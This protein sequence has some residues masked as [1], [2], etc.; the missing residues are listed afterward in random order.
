VRT[1]IAAGFVAASLAVATSAYATPAIGIEIFIDGTLVN[2]M[3]VT[4]GGGS[5]TLSF[6]NALF[7]SISVTA[8]GAPTTPDPNFGTISI[9][10]SSAFTSGTHTL[11]LVT[12]QT[13][14]TGSGFGGLANSFTYNGL[15]NPGNVTSAIGMNYVDAGDAA[16]ALTT[17]LASSGN[18]G[19]LATLSTGPI[20]FM[21]TPPPTF[22]E[23]EIYDFTFKGQALAQSSAQITGVPEP[24]SIA[25]LGTGLI[26]LGTIRRR[27][28]QVTT[29]R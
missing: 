16:Y 20:T 4:S 23:T 14:L 10:A 17:L 9:S 3:P 25:L 1:L 24:V 13:G 22:S 26:G 7:N 6:S 11:S 29:L 12:T 5:F 27:R 18:A 2:S 8:T 28:S 21:P 15:S 19:G